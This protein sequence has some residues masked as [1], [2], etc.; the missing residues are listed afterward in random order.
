MLV[1]EL[2]RAVGLGGRDR[3]GASDAERARVRVTKSVRSAVAALARV[4]AELGRHL[5][6]SVRTGS[7]CSYRSG[8]AEPVRWDVS[9]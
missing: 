6:A 8:L 2:A 1:R 5:Q 7:F 9:Q 4:D 3:P